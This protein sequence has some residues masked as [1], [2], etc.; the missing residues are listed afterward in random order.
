MRRGLAA[1]VAAQSFLPLCG[2]NALDRPIFL[3][4]ISTVFAKLPFLL[5]G[6]LGVVHPTHP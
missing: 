1:F 6:F 4:G 3:L 5:S 2:A